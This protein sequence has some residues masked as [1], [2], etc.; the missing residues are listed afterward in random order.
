MTG[1]G[2]TIVIKVDKKELESHRKDYNFKYDKEGDSYM[3]GTNRY[4]LYGHL[5]SYDVKLNQDVKKG[6]IVALSGVTGYAEGT[7]GPHLH[8]EITSKKLPSKGD[9][10]KYR[11]NPLNY[12][13]LTKEDKQYQRKYKKDTYTQK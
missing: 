12:I 9:R 2:K 8:F 5:D 1:Y 11:S 7:Q 4:L 6:D 10:Y 13:T 3:S